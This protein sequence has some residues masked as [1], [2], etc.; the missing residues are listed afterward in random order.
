M[1]RISA[2]NSSMTRSV[3]SWDRMPI[4][5]IFL[6]LALCYAML[7]TKYRAY[8]IDT[9][10]YQSISYNTWNQHIDTD[11]FME[12]T[13]PGGMGGT[14]TFGLVPSFIQALVL[15]RLGWYQ[16]NGAILSSFFVLLSLAIW[17]CFLA[18]IGWPKTQRYLYILALGLL[19]PFVSMACTSRYE[20][21]S[22]FILSLSL[23]LGSRHYNYVAIL[24]SFMAA[25]TQ[26][27][28]IVVPLTVFIFILY[29]DRPKLRTFL[30]FI[31]AAL[32][33]A[34]MYVWMHPLAIT[35]IIHA[36]WH[37]RTNAAL[38]PGFIHS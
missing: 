25:E 28:G 36:N 13:F 17:N 29:Q 38:T 27:F 9:P 16:W 2:P 21:F 32:I 4:Y 3:F 31:S 11:T 22:F 18:N 37:T 35:T 19:E 33:C 23:W 6:L 30:S 1:K 10:W 7:A 20:F 24:I 14:R 15:N 5:L 34:I 8:Q 12:F 26:A